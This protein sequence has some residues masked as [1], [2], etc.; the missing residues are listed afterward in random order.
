EGSRVDGASLAE[1]RLDIDPGFHV[2]AV[3]R[4]GRYL[5]RPRGTQR[6][7]A[8]DELIASGPSEGE[9]L[10]A[11]LCGWVLVEDDE[12]GEDRLEPVPTTA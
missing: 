6:L 10:L 1:L 9:S 2:L 7:V 4:G 8:G 11:T 5:Y 3:R 12:T